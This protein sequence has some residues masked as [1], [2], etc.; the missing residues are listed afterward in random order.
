MKRETEY[1]RINYPDLYD[2]GLVGTN[3]LVNK[4]SNI[5][6]KNIQTSLPIII[7]ELRDK[8]DEFNNELTSLGTPLPESD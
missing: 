4:L 3:N 5:L 8:I 6:G 7:K 1:F 2:L